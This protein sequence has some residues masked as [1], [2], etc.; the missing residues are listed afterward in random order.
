MIHRLQDSHNHH[1]PADDESYKSGFVVPDTESGTAGE[2]C[3]S[4]WSLADKCTCADARAPRRRAVVSSIRTRSTSYVEW[5]GVSTSSAHAC[6]VWGARVQRCHAARQC[7]MKRRVASARVC[8]AVGARVVHNYCS[9]VCTL[10]V[11][12]YQ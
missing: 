8:G 6:A 3:G 12:Q 7:P 5:C 1:Y 9:R 4:D 11:L 2:E 10:H